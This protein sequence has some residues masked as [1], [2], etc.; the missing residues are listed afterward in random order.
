MRMLVVSV[1]RIIITRRSRRSG[2]YRVYTSGKGRLPD[3]VSFSS[4]LAWKRYFFSHQ[5]GPDVWREIIE[6]E[7]FEQK[8]FILVN[9]VRPWK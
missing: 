4:M 7:A 8:T 3:L 5:V 6:K 2:R 9:P 1:D